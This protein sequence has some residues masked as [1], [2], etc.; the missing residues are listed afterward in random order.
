MRTLSMPIGNQ[1]YIVSMRRFLIKTATESGTLFKKKNNK[2]DK[3]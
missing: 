2:L 3:I 1:T